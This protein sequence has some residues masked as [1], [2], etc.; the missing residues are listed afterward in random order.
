MGT[1]SSVQGSGIGSRASTRR[2]NRTQLGNGATNGVESTRSMISGGT[3]AQSI[4]ISTTDSTRHSS[5]GGDQITRRSVSGSGSTSRHRSHE[6]EGITGS[7]NGNAVQVEESNRGSFRSTS[8]HSPSL[9]LDDSTLNEEPFANVEDGH[10]NNATIKRKLGATSIDHTFAPPSETKI[11][12]TDHLELVN[13][14]F[15]LLAKEFG[16]YFEMDVIKAA[17]TVFITEPLFTVVT[18]GSEPLGIYVIVEGTFSYS[19]PG[20]GGLTDASPLT[21]GLAL[22][23]LSHGEMFGEV[24]TLMNIPNIMNVTCEER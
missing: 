11:T 2:S 24:S 10:T 18:A 4:I 19:S 3:I 22:G 16:V 23:T 15:E 13:D 14:S 8:H 21:G 20:D 1:V 9:S 12:S 17:A 7:A 6:R 5:H